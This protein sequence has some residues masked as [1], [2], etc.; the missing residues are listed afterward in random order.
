MKQNSIHTKLTR[1]YMF[2]ISAIVLL[3]LAG[4]LATILIS[5][6]PSARL[7]MQNA[8]AELRNRIGEL[9]QDLESAT[10]ALFL[11]LNNLDYDLMLGKTDN[12]LRRY[13]EINRSLYLARQIYANVDWAFFIDMEGAVYADNVL[14][15]RQLAQK[16]DRSRNDLLAA[17]NGRTVCLGLCLDPGIN[18]H[19]PV[20]MVGKFAR[21]ISTIEGTGCLYLCMNQSRLQTLFDENRITS[22]QQIYLYDADGQILSSTQTD[23]IGTQLDLGIDPQKESG[24]FFYQGA[25]WLFQRSLLKGMNANLVI[26]VPFS[27][28]FSS[29]SLS[30][31]LCLAVAIAGTLL[32]LWQA[33]HIADRLV[34]PLRNLTESANQIASGDIQS[35]CQVSTDDEIGVLADSFNSMLD[36]I[37]ALIEEIEAEHREKRRKEIELAQNRIQPHFL[38]NTLN[39]ISALASMERSAQA[40]QMAKEMA[41]YYRL[42]LND[43]RDIITIEQELENI[44]SYLRICEISRQEPFDYTISCMEDAKKQMIPKMVIQPLVENSITHGFRG[45]R[46]DLL[47]IAI[48]MEEDAE[49]TVMIEVADNGCGM[50]AHKLAKFRSDEDT[51]GYGLRSVRERLHLF[52]GKDCSLWADSRPGQ[53]TLIRICYHIPDSE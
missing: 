17:S 27:E 48:H 15:E 28:L 29:S 2:L 50:E 4:S 19:E 42:I 26:I 32:A 44:E 37:S 31:L 30:I 10:N 13:N 47:T 25:P 52:S 6:L 53:G 24:L 45:A 36:R 46:S 21:Y 34:M 16:F 49:N 35:R 1:S 38:Y 51:G 23:A 5:A 14:L 18:A 33:S 9:E 43:G 20:L 41:K 40:A 12:Q 8:D 3:M 22:R 11:N 39:T 7:A